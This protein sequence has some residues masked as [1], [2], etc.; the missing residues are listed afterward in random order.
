MI[1]GPHI[2][3]LTC[4]MLPLLQQQDRLMEGPLDVPERDELKAKYNVHAR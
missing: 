3:K 4:S 1:V 2:V